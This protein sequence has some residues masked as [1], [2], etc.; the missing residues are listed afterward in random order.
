MS[1]SLAGYEIKDIEPLEPL[2]NCAVKENY[3]S[4]ESPVDI[5]NAVDALDDMAQNNVKND[6]TLDNLFSKL[7]EADYPRCIALPIIAC[8]CYDVGELNLLHHLEWYNDRD[9]LYKLLITL[10]LVVNDQ[11]SIKLRFHCQDSQYNNI[12][13]KEYY[14]CPPSGQIENNGSEE[15]E[16]L[17]SELK[18]YKSGSKSNYENPHS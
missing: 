11:H 15:I 16:K 17:F 2:F 3:V 8:I 5:A 1:N 4:I 18:F 9:N 13:N 14:F 7:L 6:Q 10:R 12:H